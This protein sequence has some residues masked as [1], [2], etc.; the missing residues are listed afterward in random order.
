MGLD[1]GLR[2][3]G[4]RLGAV[5]RAPTKKLPLSASPSPVPTGEG[6]GYLPDEAADRRRRWVPVGAHTLGI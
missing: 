2:R 5:N 6:T 4:E 1:C 3:N